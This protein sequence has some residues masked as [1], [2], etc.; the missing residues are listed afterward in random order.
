MKGLRFDRLEAKLLQ[1]ISDGDDVT[2]AALECRI[3]QKERK[4]KK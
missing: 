2:S 1:A 4:Q 3:L